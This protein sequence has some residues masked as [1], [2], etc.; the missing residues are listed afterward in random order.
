MHVAMQWLWLSLVWFRS[1]S[2]VPSSLLV[3]AFQALV[4]LLAPASLRSSSYI[5][6]VITQI[7]FG[8]GGEGIFNVREK[9]LHASNFCATT[10][11]M[12]NTQA[13]QLH[14][15]KIMT[16]CHKII[17]RSSIATRSSLMRSTKINS[18]LYVEKAKQT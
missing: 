12:K 3:R 15:E 7:L 4:M 16:Q 5:C 13:A 17:L 8:G 1:P 10:L 2:G 18:I 6:L 9:H 11:H 14:K